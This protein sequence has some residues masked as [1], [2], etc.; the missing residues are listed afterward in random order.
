M[1]KLAAYICK[2]TFFQIALTKTYN[3]NNLKDNI[4][5]L[6]DIAGP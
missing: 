1:T 5:E 3:D 4:R 2:H 6:Y